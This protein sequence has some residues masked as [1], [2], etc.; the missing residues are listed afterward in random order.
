MSAKH[1]TFEANQLCWVLYTCIRFRKCKIPLQISFANIFLK[2]TLFSLTSQWLFVTSYK[3][4][5]KYLIV[6]CSKTK[7]RN[8]NWNKN[9]CRHL[10]T[11]H[12][13][14]WYRVKLGFKF[15]F[16]LIFLFPIG[17]YFK[18][19]QEKVAFSVIL[20][21]KKEKSEPMEL[22]IQEHFNIVSSLSCNTEQWLGF[23]L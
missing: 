3:N 9:L 16:H 12:Q 2:T 1:I 11:S 4:H 10:L 17:K 6:C 15:Q 8:M 22:Y 20:Y 13:C 21:S 7:C 14:F 23:L 18:L 19:Q 5:Q